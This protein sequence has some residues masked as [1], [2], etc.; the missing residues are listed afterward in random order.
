[1]SPRIRAKV[2]SKGQ[3]TLPAPLRNELRLRAGDDV[4]FIKDREGRYLVEAR[5]PLLHDLKGFIR[6]VPLVTG[7]DIRGW[8]DE[9][10]GRLPEGMKR[11]GG[12]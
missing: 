1:M 6:D 11:S 4:T 10:R 3:I 9:A 12:R 5:S 2:T 7:D 8:I